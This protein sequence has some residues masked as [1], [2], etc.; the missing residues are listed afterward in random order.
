L[1][2][3]GLGAWSFPV[4]VSAFT[5]FTLGL[6][7]F[8]DGRFRPR[9]MRWVAVLMIAFA[10]LRA[11]GIHVAPPNVIGISFMVIAIAALIL[12]YRTYAPGGEQQQIR[13]AMLGFGVAVGLFAI[14]GLIENLVL[15][16]DHA[17]RLWIW[18]TV[19]DVA[20]IDAALMLASGGLLVSLL[21]YRL[22][23][24]DALI[25]RSV[26]YGGLTLVLLGVFAGSEKIIELLGEEW[27]G[28]E[29]GVLAGGIGAAFAAVMFVPLHHRLSH[30]AEHK[31]QKRLIRLRTGLPL[32]VG[33]MRQ[34]ARTARIAAAVLDGLSEGVRAGRAALIFDGH[35]LGA[36]GIEADDV[37]RWREEWVPP[38]REGFDIDRGDP[39]F[40]LRV[41]LA[42][43]GHGRIGWLLLGP[44]PDGS[45]YGKDERETLAQIADPV[46]CALEIAAARE[47]RE[48]EERAAWAEQRTL[49]QA[50]LGTLQA[51]DG[52][53]DRLFAPPAE[54]AE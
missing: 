22:Y 33:D 29:L 42:A 25:T 3:L 11:A 12:R 10:F 21:R 48:A 41:P 32:I 49:N 26:A 45:F 46:A 53:L 7:L 23:D 8:P 14:S 38:L 15:P 30:W 4:L 27:F 28:K 2:R 35:L 44:R 37:E 16:F 52:K 13:W 47:V 50:L 9:W 51:L 36:R 6:M 24:A 54:A 1:S 19:A 18:A 20:A 43:D 31:F 5:A 40:P 17:P 39:L 34:T